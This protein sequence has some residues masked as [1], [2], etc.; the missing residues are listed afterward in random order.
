MW[1]VTALVL[2]DLVPLGATLEPSEVQMFAAF[3]GLGELPRTHL[4]VVLR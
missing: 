4:G 3:V 2:L 1:C